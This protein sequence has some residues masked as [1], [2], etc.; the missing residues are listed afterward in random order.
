M[1]EGETILFIEKNRISVY[2][3][4]G[5]MKLDIPQNIV[6]DFDIVDKSGFDGTL[7]TFIK[8]KKL[9]PNHTWVVLS[10]SVCFSRDFDQADPLK[11]EDEIKDFLESV[12]FN[13]VVSKRYKSQTGV[14]VIATNL[15]LVEGLTEVFEGDGFSIDIVIPGAIFPELGIGK[16]LNSET[17]RSII[18]N[19]SLADQGNMLAKTPLPKS[20]AEPA[21]KPQKSKLLPVLIGVFALLIT[22]LVVVLISN[23]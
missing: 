11:L 2:A 9:S 6:R 1:A 12:P 23:R 4:D 18:Q 7:D 16:T 22:V 15:E 8:S 5:I 20:N 19:R 13:Q 14:R 21:G 10:D 17:A 3:G